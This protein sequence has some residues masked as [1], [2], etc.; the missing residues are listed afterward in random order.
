MELPKDAW[1]FESLLPAIFPDLFGDEAT[2]ECLYRKLLEDFIKYEL[3]RMTTKNLE[4]M[5][6]T[7]FRLMKDNRLFISNS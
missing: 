5:L 6:F 3:Q 7:Y 2:H 4:G 1:P